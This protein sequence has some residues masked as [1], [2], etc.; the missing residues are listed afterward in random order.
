MAT[1]SEHLAPG[2]SAWFSKRPRGA[3]IEA[4]SPRVVE[5]IPL[6]VRDRLPKTSSG[7]PDTAAEQAKGAKEA[8]RKVVAA[9]GSRVDM[10]REN[11]LGESI[12][13]SSVVGRL[14][15]GAGH[16]EPSTDDSGIVYAH[17]A[18]Q[19]LDNTAT[20]H[21][22]ERVRAVAQ[23]HLR[24]HDPRRMGDAVYL[25]YIDSDN[26]DLQ[27]MEEQGGSIGVLI[28]R[29]V[30]ARFGQETKKGYL[31]PTR[32]TWL[33]TNLGGLPGRFAVPEAINLRQADARR[34]F[35]TE[36]VGTEFGQNSA[37]IA[38]LN[39]GELLAVEH[40]GL[41]VALSPGD[42]MTLSLT[43]TSMRGFPQ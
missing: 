38:H 17:S 35:L 28:V 14:L 12:S 36:V 31:R 16:I 11:I 18:E 5:R 40:N 3:G 7:E 22:D 8:W 27:L 32:T 29:P 10:G 24:N 19:D 20:M 25:T 9:L 33:A 6:P 4:R 21:S 37:K 15:R 41:R 23:A 34:Q 42:R 2:V 1:S 26:P 13:P 30:L 39:E 43:E